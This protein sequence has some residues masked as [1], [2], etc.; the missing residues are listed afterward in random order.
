MDLIEE[1]SQEYMPDDLLRFP[2]HLL[3]KILLQ[4]DPNEYKKLIQLGDYATQRYLEDEDFFNEYYSLHV[5]DIRGTIGD[6]RTLTP[7]LGNVKYGD[8]EGWHPNDR[9]SYIKRWLDGRQDENEEG[10]YDNGKKTYIKRWLDGRQYGNEEMWSEDHQKK[11]IKKWYN[12]YHDG[13][14]QMWTYYPSSYNI[15]WIK[16]GRIIKEREYNIHY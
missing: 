3:E 9:K 13:I 2:D 16:D 10:W 1:F 6:I 8:E 7:Y 12:G 15:K 11:Y 4:I 5:R 14:E